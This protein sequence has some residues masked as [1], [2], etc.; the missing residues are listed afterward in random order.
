MTIENLFRA[1]DEYVN[2][3]REERDKALRG[4]NSQA[5]ID[6]QKAMKDVDDFICLAMMKY[7]EPIHKSLT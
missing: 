6:A 7:A 3:K 5:Q 4:N 1:H 2:L